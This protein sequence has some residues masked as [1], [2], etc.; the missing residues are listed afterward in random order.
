[1]LLAPPPTT[2]RYLHLA[3][4]AARAGRAGLAV[5]LCS[6]LQA[7]RIERFAADLGVPFSAAAGDDDAASADAVE[8][9]EPR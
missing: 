2:A 7:P 9:A 5:T 1:V 4:R 6:P 3:G 8:T